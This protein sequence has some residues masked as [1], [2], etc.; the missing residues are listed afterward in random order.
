MRLA[1]PPSNADAFHPSKIS[2]VAL[3]CENNALLYV[4]YLYDFASPNGK[5]ESGHVVVHDSS[6]FVIIALRINTSR[7]RTGKKRNRTHQWST[8]WNGAGKRTC[9]GTFE[10]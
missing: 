2:K 5:K 7:K 3:S 9:E 6:P 10:S 8:A 1:V 4:P